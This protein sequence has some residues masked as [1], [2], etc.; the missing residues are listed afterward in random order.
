M[1]PNDDLARWGEPPT[2]ADELALAEALTQ[3]TRPTHLRGAGAVFE[4]ND[5]MRQLIQTVVEQSG[6]LA[7]LAPPA[8]AGEPTGAG[9][10]RLAVSRLLPAGVQPVA[11]THA[12]PMALRDLR[13]VPEDADRVPLRTGDRVRVEVVCDRVGHLAILNVGPGGN[14]HLLH[15]GQAVRPGEARHL[16]DVELIPPAGRERLYAIWTRHPAGVSRLAELIRPGAT[17]RDMV[18]V[19]DALE[20]LPEADWHAVLLELDHRATA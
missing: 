12:M 18:R 11:S 3:E 16:F 20:R 9:W 19:Q 15:H 13:R 7:N 4:T 5:W 8:P 10:L 2:D 1:L 6:L 14:L 17:L